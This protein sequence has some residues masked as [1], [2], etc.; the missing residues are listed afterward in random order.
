MAAIGQR[1]F[2]AGAFEGTLPAPGHTLQSS[3]AS[4]GFVAALDSAG[5]IAWAQSL[6]GMGH[7][8]ISALAA[9]GTDT[10][11]ITAALSHSA[12]V[13]LAEHRLASVAELDAALVTFDASGAIAR[14]E[15]FRASRYVH[16][17]ALAYGNDGSLAVAGAFAGTIR[18]ADRVLTSAGETDLFAALF[19]PEGALS[20]AIRAGGPHADGASDIALGPDSLALVGSFSG[21]AVFASQTVTSPSRDRRRPG[22]SG[23]IA[24]LDAKNGQLVR[25]VPLPS[26]SAAATAVAFGSEGQLVCVGHFDVALGVQGK[27]LEARGKSDVFVVRLD[28]RGE[29]TWAKQLGGAGHDDAVDLARVGDLW[30]IGGTFEDAATFGEKSLASAGKRDVY[31]A[32][33]SDAGE[34]LSARSLGGPDHDDLGALGAGAEASLY[35]VGTFS[36]TAAIAGPLSATGQQSAFVAKLGL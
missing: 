30:V 13:D 17:R 33:S 7:D 2:V 5:R 24:T 4:D 28:A 10:P 34:V 6:G 15:A 20:W 12:A 8:S 14:V 3:G 35:L 25:L 26:P 1:A 16:I 36:G 11:R 9:Y 31:T 18:I 22:Q 19:N 23:Y 29:L 27:V 32:V 21:R